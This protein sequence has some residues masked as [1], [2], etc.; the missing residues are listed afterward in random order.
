[1]KVELAQRGVGGRLGRAEPAIEAVAIE[2]VVVEGEEHEVDDETEEADE[3]EHVGRQ[4][5]GIHVDDGVPERMH[6]VAGE[7]RVVYAA[8]FVFVQAEQVLATKILEREDFCKK[9]WHVVIATSGVRVCKKVSMLPCL[10][11]DILFLSL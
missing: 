11:Y 2:A 5:H 1:M 7:R 9:R 8:V 6:D 10:I 4:P 3:G